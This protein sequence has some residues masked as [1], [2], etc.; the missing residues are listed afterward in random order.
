MIKKLL[1]TVCIFAATSSVCEAYVIGG[2]GYPPYG[3]YGWT[4]PTGVRYY[5]PIN[6]YD[7]GN[8]WN[9]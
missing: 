9:C 3:G 1:L 2:F 6:R 7:Y 4:Y 8:C 5:R